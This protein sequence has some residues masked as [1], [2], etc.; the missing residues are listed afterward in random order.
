MTREP[1]GPQHTGHAWCWHHQ[2]S[3]SEY[4][5]LSMR[6]EHTRSQHITRER[7][8]KASSLHKTPTTKQPGD[9]VRHDLHSKTSQRPQHLTTVVNQT[10]PH[11]K[12]DRI[13]IET[14]MFQ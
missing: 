14:D 1:N 7:Q 3:C 4:D 8:P 10:A 9:C 5:G 12:Q 6:R 13:S 11:C 2:A